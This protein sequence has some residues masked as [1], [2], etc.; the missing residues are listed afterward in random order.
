MKYVLAIDEG[1]T[2]ATCLMIG[3]DGRVAG[4]GYREIPQYFPQPGWVEHDAIEI[5]EC[6]RVAAREAIGAV[7]TPPVADRHHESARDGRDLGARDGTAG[8]SRDRVAGSSNRGAL[9][10]ACAAR[11]LDR[12]AYRLLPDPY[13]SAT[14][15]RVAAATKSVCS[16]AIAPSDLAVGTIDSWLVWQL[17]GG[18]VH[19]TDP[20]NASRTM[21]YDIDRLRVE[22]G[23]VRAVRR[24]DGDAARGAPVERRLRR[25]RR[26]AMLGVDVPI[27]GIAG[28]QQAALF[29]QGCW[30]R[31][32]GKNTYGTGAFLLLNAGAERP[33]ARRRIADDDRLR[34]APAGR[35]TRSR[36]RS[37]SPA[38]RC[39]GCATDL[40]SSRTRARPRRWRGRSSR[41]TACTSCPR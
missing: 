35:R 34:R 28:D 23:A 7:G 10:G 36:R 5:L 24:A 4:R 21:L 32:S 2:G 31:G 22:R 37:S 29:G 20:T 41:P 19:A 3:E 16:S 38:P 18:A 13:F 30:T 39:S 11:R 40:A 25:R 15:D 17:T 27:L 8:P 14:Q 6:V 12:R 9:P 1:T 33:A 26:G